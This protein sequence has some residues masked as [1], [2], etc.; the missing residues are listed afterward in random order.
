MFF[1]TCEEEMM[2]LQ[3]LGVRKGQNLV[4]YAIIVSLVSAAMIAVSTYVYRSVQAAQKNIEDE[5]RK[6]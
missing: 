5:F 6:N 2:R 1:V 4:E 3:K